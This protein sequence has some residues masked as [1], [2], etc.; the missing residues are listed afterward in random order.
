MIVVELVYSVGCC[1][2]VLCEFVCL[3]VL[4]CLSGLG[5]LFVL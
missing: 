3:L 4:L 5:G 1:L 2:L